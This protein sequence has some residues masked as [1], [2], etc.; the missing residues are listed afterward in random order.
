[1]IIV[2]DA[3]A[4]LAVLFEEPSANAV[5]DRIIGQEMVAPVLLAFEIANACVTRKR[6]QPPLSLASADLYALY[7][8][9]GVR[10]VPVDYPGIIA[11]AEA[12]RLTAYDASYLWLAQYLGC[13]LVTLDRRLSR[14]AS[15]IP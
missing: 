14:A 10:L 7:E 12:A 3:S 13:E 5:E 2:V 9:W 15:A 4:V 11:L 8:E 1:M 6:R